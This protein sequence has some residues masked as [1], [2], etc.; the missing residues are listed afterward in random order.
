MR[1]EEQDCCEEIEK[2]EEVEDGLLGSEGVWGRCE[3]E[4]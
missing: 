3:V 1:C 4:I 2:D